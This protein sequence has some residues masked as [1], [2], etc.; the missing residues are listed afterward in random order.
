MTDK[1]DARGFIHN[2]KTYKA[3]FKRLL[4]GVVYCY[5]MMIKENA[6]LINDEND[7][8][9]KLIIEY[10]NN[11]DVRPLAGLME[12]TFNKEVDEYKTKGRTDIKIEIRNPF[13][14]TAAYYIF[15]CKRLNKINTL[16]ISGLNAKYIKEGI[17]RFVSKLYSTNCKINAMIGFIVEEMDIHSNI[18]NINVLSKTK[19]IE[20]AKIIQE[21]C[22]E[23]FIHD[24]DFHYKSIHNDCDNNEFTLYHLMFDMSGLLVME[25]KRV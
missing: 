13:R 17:Y 24:F 16:G 1:L 22:K 6:E 4:C 21:I 25:E 3:E 10:L 11:D 9:D 18:K 2:A 19:F 20:E 23:N 14:S 7:I 5:K 8:R 12:F 15:E